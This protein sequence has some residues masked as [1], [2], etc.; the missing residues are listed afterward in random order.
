M[1]PLGPIR[2]VGVDVSGKTEHCI[3]KVSKIPNPTRVKL[4]LGKKTDGLPVRSRTVSGCMVGYPSPFLPV[5]E[6]EFS[7]LI[8]QRVFNE[9]EYGVTD[10]ESVYQCRSTF[11]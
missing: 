5:E 6:G 3:T 4:L 7:V 2:R 9:G 10:V 1:E 11:P 8:L